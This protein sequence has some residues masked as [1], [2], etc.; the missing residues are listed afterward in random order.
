MRQR[1]QGLGGGSEGDSADSVLDER[2]GCLGPPDHELDRAGPGKT[3]LFGQLGSGCMCHLHRTVAPIN[4]CHLVCSSAGRPTLPCALKIAPRS[5]QSRQHR[6]RPSPCNRGASPPPAA[7]QSRQHA[8]RCR[9]AIGTAP[10][11]RPRL[12]EPQQR[13]AVRRPQSQTPN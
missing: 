6:L 10:P 9:R 1:T 13:A 11:Q 5:F 2:A 12:I 3:S 8:S 4:R 7:V